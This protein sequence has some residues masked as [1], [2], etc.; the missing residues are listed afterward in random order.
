[1]VAD[2]FFPGRRVLSMRGAHAGRVGGRGKQKGMALRRAVKNLGSERGEARRGGLAGSGRRPW[3]L[4]LVVPLPRAMAGR[5]SGLPACRDSK[6]KRA[7]HMVWRRVTCV[8]T[9]SSWSSLPGVSVCLS[10]PETFSDIC[11]K[12][13]KLFPIPASRRPAVL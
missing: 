4:V 6:S 3:T 7:S 2:F 8:P 11:F 9:N 1:M 10:V 12:K 13:K 5:A